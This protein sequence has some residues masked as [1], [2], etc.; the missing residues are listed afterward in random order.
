VAEESDIVSSGMC[1]SVD[2]AAVQDKACEP[3][4]ESKSDYQIAIE[5]A[6]CFGLE[7]ELSEGMSIEEWQQ[8]A[9][10]RSQLKNEISW[11]ELK[12]KGYY[13]PPFDPN[14]KDGPTGMQGFYENP[15]K[16]PM[17]T[18]T[19]KIEFYSQALQDHFPDDKE[20]TP[21]ARWITGGPESEG[22]T[23]DETQWGEKAKTYPLLLN[24]NPGRWRVHVQGDDITWFREIETCK[25]IGFDGYAYEPMWIYPTDAA[26]RGLKNGDIVKVTNDQGTILAG[27]RISE[28]VL[29]GSIMINKGARVDPIAP[30]IDR[31]GSTNLISTPKPIS[32]NCWGFAVTGYLVEATKLEP[33]EMEQWKKQYPEAFARD[34]D[35]MRGVLRSAWVEGD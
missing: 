6:K 3:V 22:W 25:V 12:E 19:G 20:R 13:I 2:Y 29:P 28:R 27:T 7:D 32:K 26:K 23:H 10:D 21:I 34:Y 24:A 18:P 30:G 17:D 31:G 5:V 4:G 16:Y 11:E 8:F 1:V 35:P 15:E 33:A 14:W 9:F